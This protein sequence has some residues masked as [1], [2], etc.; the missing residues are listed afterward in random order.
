MNT[1]DEEVKFL[2][3]TQDYSFMF[4]HDRSHTSNDKCE[5]IVHN[6]TDTQGRSLTVARGTT[7]M[8]SFKGK[9]L[10]ETLRVAYSVSGMWGYWTGKPSCQNLVNSCILYQNKYFYIELQIYLVSQIVCILDLLCAWVH[11]SKCDLKRGYW[12]TSY[13]ERKD[14]RATRIF[15][16][17]IITL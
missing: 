15:V 3:D 7:K 14:K 9:G 12:N 17:A 13:W 5:G 4:Y 11:A 16:R 10:R 8:S 2:Y 6:S 1:S